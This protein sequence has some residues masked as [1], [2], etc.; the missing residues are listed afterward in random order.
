MEFYVVNTDKWSDTH[1]KTS[2]CGY[3]T[4]NAL[5][6]QLKV[7]VQNKLLYNISQGKLN[8]MYYPIA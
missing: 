1:S 2:Q 4:I 5:G 8:V 6:L 3:W 7:V